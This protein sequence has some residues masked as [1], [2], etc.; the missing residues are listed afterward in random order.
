MKLDGKKVRWHRDRLGW[1]LDALAEKAEVAKG[2]VLR[3]EHGEDIRPSSGRRIARA[4]RVEIPE[5]I[6]EK[7]G[8]SSSKASAPLLFKG[9]LEERCDH[10]YL[11]LSDEE[12]EEEFEKAHEAEEPKL[13]EELF[14]AVTD[15][16]MAVMKP[17]DVSSE[18]K[19]L[20]R[21]NRGSATLKWAK[22][23][24]ASGLNINADEKFQKSVEEA[25]QALAE[26][27]A[28]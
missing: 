9:W 20:L 4:F 26:A 3:A 11:A 8:A 5:L 6:P 23:F 24:N 18:E 27:M 17:T 1:T 25:H 15:E 22:A 13:V 2:T 7:P 28:V 12:L 16:L 14:L 19:M 10:A 21:G